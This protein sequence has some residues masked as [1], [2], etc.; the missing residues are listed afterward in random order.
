MRP[1]WPLSNRQSRLKSENASSCK[2]SCPAAV[3]PIEQASVV[4]RFLPLDSRPKQKQ[5]DRARRTHTAPIHP[6]QHTTN[7]IAPTFHT[8]SRSTRRSRCTI[9]NHHIYLHHS[10]HS[11]YAQQCDAKVRCPNWTHKHTH[12]RLYETRQ[13]NIHFYKFTQIITP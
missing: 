2:W 13:T 7:T 5:N 12:I 4:N 9:C 1:F 6:P 8:T 3:S 10:P 11:K